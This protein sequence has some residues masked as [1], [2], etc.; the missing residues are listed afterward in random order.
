MTDLP[1]SCFSAA[2]Y[3]FAYRYASRFWC[4]DLVMAALMAGAAVAGKYTELVTPLL[5]GLAIVPLMINKRQIWFHVVPAAF[6]FVI[7]CGVW[8]A[9]NIILLGNPVY[10]FLFSH[11]GLSNQWMADYMRDMTRPFNVA[12]RGYSTNL[13]TLRGWRDF[14]VVLGSYFSNLTFAAMLAV[15][16]LLLPL[17]RRWL[18]PAWTLLLFIFWY[19]VMF[20]GE[21]WAVTAILTLLAAAVMVWMSVADRIVAAWDPHWPTLV[22]ES[23]VRRLRRMPDP[24]TAAA[25]LLLAAFFLFGMVRFKDGYGHSFLPSWMSRD[26]ASAILAPGGFDRYLTETKPGYAMYRYI[27]QHNLSLVLQPFDDGAVSYVSAYNGGHPNDWIL[28]Y[29]DLPENAA[30]ADTFAARNGVH[31]FVEGPSLDATAME[32]FGRD[33][34]RRLGTGRHR[35]ASKLHSRLIFQDGHGMSLF[36]MLPDRHAIQELRRGGCGRQTGR[37][38]VVSLFPEGG[39]DVKA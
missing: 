34:S 30:D 21:R 29:G 17:A 35:A 31:Y 22:L 14:L 12:D 5:I 28:P 25:S 39:Q 15:F 36:Q 33:C 11:P 3:L 26:M 2:A 24:W 16:G 7:V 6:I 4:F 23:G 9:K 38:R 32:E 8:Y 27:G 19:A 10:P 1:R 37:R 18:L 13:L 20:N